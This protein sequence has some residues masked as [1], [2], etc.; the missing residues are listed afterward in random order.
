MEVSMEEFQGKVLLVD[1]DKVWLHF[2]GRR[3]KRLKIA[4]A[5]ARNGLEALR[6]LRKNPLDFN[7]VIT[8]LQMPYMNG[9]SLLAFLRARRSKLPVIV[10]SSDFSW[11]H[12]SREDFEKRG[13]IAVFEKE[14]AKACMMPLVREL[15][16]RQK[17]SVQMAHAV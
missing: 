17:D 11:A 5:Q 6:F 4:T 1:D 16:R 12:L 15:F 10:V 8:G 7:L 3:L 13:A 2:L 9:L 14:Q